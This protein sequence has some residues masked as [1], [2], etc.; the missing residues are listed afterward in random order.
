LLDQLLGYYRDLMIAAAGCSAENYLHTG[1]AEHAQVAAAAKKLGLETILASLQILDHTL[2]RLRFSAHGRILAELALVRIA[3][4]DELDKLAD[5]LAELREGGLASGNMGSATSGIA[6]K[7]ADLNAAAG[8]WPTLSTATA[9]HSGSLQS[10]AAPASRAENPRLGAAIDPNSA[11]DETASHILTAA[12]ALEMFREAAASLGDMTADSA[13]QASAAAIRAPNQLVVT[14]P[15][16]Y[17]FGKSIC[18]SP[19]RAARLEQALAEL[20]GQRIRLE[21]ALEE[22]PA[23]DRIAATAPQ[24]APSVR[25]RHAELM[26]NPLVRRAA[27]LFDARPVARE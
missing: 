20:I 8:P 17:N 10:P 18:E 14:F 11:A 25:E 27:E 19:D 12:N 13:M 26:K 5:V 21:F 3:K 1:P 15:A 2:S 24:R 7:K 16:K 4:L 6:K 23:T 9:S 22:T